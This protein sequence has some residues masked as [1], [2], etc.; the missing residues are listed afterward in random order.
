VHAVHGGINRCIRRSA[1]RF[2]A[3]GVIEVVKPMQVQSVGGCEGPSVRF[4]RLNGALEELPTQEIAYEIP[5][6]VV[7]ERSGNWFRIRLEMGSGW[8]QV[9]PSA[10]PNRFAAYPDLINEDRLVYIDAGWD[11]KL[12]SQP[13]LTSLLKQLSKEVASARRKDYQLRSRARATHR[14]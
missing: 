3:N 9:D 14:R 13:S 11:G 10:I 1:G 2:S 12:Y 6:A 8:I 7:Y 4:R 5:A